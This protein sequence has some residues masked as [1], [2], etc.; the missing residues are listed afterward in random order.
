MKVK[1]LLIALSLIFLVSCANNM[2]LYRDDIKGFDLAKDTLPKSPYCDVIQSEYKTGKKVV[3]ASGT[4]WVDPVSA[5]KRH[6]VCRAGEAGCENSVVAVTSITQERQHIFDNCKRA[7]LHKKLIVKKESAKQEVIVA[8]AI[9]DDT[10]RSLAFDQLVDK[11]LKK[12]VI[13]HREQQYLYS[14]FSYFTAALIKEADI[15]DLEGSI[16]LG[17]AQP[18]VDPLSAVP[19]PYQVQQ[20]LDDMVILECGRCSL[21]PIGIKRVN[22]RP[23]PVEKQIFNDTRAIYKFVGTQHY[24]TLL[25]ERRQ[26][27]LFDRIS[28]KSLGLASNYLH[29]VMPKDFL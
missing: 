15:T 9:G 10:K 6:Y 25:N 17:T 18:I 29:E 14:N 27:I 19:Y 16:L 12:K 11:L 28:M 5:E 1:S 21:P 2:V 13:A 3:V 23:S 7:Q 22:G 4:R 8:Q 24:R 26:V 20:V